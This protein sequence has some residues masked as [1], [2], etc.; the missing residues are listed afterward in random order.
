MVKTLCITTAASAALGLA[1]DATP[2]SRATVR[3]ASATRADLDAARGD[4][5]PDEFPDEACHRASHDAWVAVRGAAFLASPRNET[6]EGPEG[7]LVVSVAEGSGATLLEASARADAC[8][9]D[10]AR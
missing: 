4:S 5:D 3:A 10:A 2:L 7:S 8:V 6:P 1:V 9:R